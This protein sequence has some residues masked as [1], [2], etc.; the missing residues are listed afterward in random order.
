MGWEDMT[1]ELAGAQDV[2]EVIRWAETLASG[3][4][5]QAVAAFQY[6]TA[7]T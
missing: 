4:G 7:N 6:K 1:F 5:R 2:R 3:E